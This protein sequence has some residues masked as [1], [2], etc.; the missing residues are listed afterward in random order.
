MTSRER[1]LAAISGQKPDHVPL[2]AWVFGFKAPEHLTWERDGHKRTFWYTGRLEHL[3]RLPQAWNIEDDFKRAETWLSLGLDDVLDVSVPWNSDARVT[4]ADSLHPAHQDGREY[5]VM[6]REYQ[7][8]DGPLRHSVQKTNEE[9]KPG[10]VIQP[11]CVPLIEDFNIPRAVKH[12]V[13][14]PEDAAK[15]KW[16][17]QGP[18]KSQQAWFEERM[19]KAAGFAGERGVM[20]QAWSAFGMDAAVW[21]AGAEGAIMLCMEHPD[22]F[23]ELL[24]AIH[25]ADKA[26]TALALQYPVDMVCQRG[27]YS[28]TDFWSPSIFKKYLKPHIAELAGMAHKAGK[29]FG[30]V[31]TTGV[32]TLGVELMDA[33]VDLLYYVDPVQD[34]ADLAKAKEMF[35]GKMAVAGGVNSG[36]TLATGTPAQVRAEVKT[37]L[38]IFGKDGGF[39][40]SPVDAL[41]PDTPWN[42]VETMI[43]AWKQA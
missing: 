11:D 30:Y 10:W 16:L 26:R 14:A 27:W 43:A 21:F 8:P 31:M 33:G 4:F 22:A 19:R 41:F 24:G 12:L 34:H 7:T 39:V 6:T 37:A 29:K 25:A 9:E 13:A 17:F 23:A 36:V 32:M 42:N 1:M 2:Y 40:L 20:A 18:D 28:S 15:I 3:H 5:P 38:D 35:G